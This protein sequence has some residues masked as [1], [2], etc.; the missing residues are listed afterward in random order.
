VQTRSRILDSDITKRIS[1]VTL[2]Q[3][4]K[5]LPLSVTLGLSAL[6]QHYTTS[7]QVLTSAPVNICIMLHF[8][9]G[10]L[11]M[12]PNSPMWHIMRLQSCGPSCRHAVV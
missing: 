8:C 2:D 12:L 7:G 9:T 6:G 11:L 1:T 3:H 10:P 5:I 4:W